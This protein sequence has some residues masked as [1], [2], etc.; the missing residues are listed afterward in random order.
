MSTPQ[1]D[2]V[3]VLMLE[4]R[5]FDSL[6]G[7]AYQTGAPSL[8]LPQGSS[9]TFDG[10]QSVNLNEFVNTATNPSISSPPIQ[11]AQGFTVPTVDPGEEL[12]HVNL[13]FFNT[14][15]FPPPDPANMLGYM[16]DFVNVMTALGIDVGDIPGLAPQVM[17]SYTPQQLP[18]LNQL[19][20]AYAVSDAWYASVPS[21]TNPNR[22]FLMCGTSLGLVNNGQ[23]E[24]PNSPAK[25]IESMLGMSIGD[26]RFDAPTIFNALDK[27]GRGWSVFWQAPYLPQK[28]STLLQ[29]GQTLATVLAVLAPTVGVA[30]LAAWKAL[31]PYVGYM[32]SLTNGQLGSCYTWRLFPQIQNIS[33]A[34]S[35]FQS[36]DQFHKL[37]QAGNLPA[38]SYIEPY[39]SISQ[40][41]MASQ[42]SLPK[43]LITALGND[44]HP[45]SNLLVGEQFVKDVY[46][47]LISHQDAWQ[48]TLFLITFDEFVG[49]FDHETTGLQQG[50]AQPPWGAGTPPPLATQN[51]FN[52]DRFGGRVPTIVISP[53][54]QAGTVFRSPT[55]TPY[56]HTS[57]IA[58]ALKLLGGSENLP[59]FGSRA[60]AAPTFDNV[61]TLSQPR[62]DAANLG[63]MDKNHNTGDPVN[64]GDNFLL[65]NKNGHHL[66]AFQ[67]AGKVTMPSVSSG[68]MSMCV[69]VGVAALFP[70]LGE[71]THAPLSFVTP[72]PNVS[73]QVPDQAQTYLISREAG[74]WAANALGAWNDS[75]DC[76]YYT[77]YFDGQYLPYQT[78]TIQ[79]KSR[80]GQ[81]LCYGDQVVL[82]N[83]QFQPQGLTRDTRWGQSSWITTSTSPDTWTIEPAPV[84]LPS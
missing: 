29:Y 3:V 58:T 23:L 33:N 26:D 61:M 53:Y 10:L 5:S 17:Q 35:K 44:Y 41:T 30:V 81:P 16:Q 6:L 76:Y 39:W 67:S 31:Q 48:K 45:P 56:D 60:E 11:G 78:W 65:L 72:A 37:A 73:G 68:V 77:P 57:M 71:G 1:I 79:N 19:A 46:T 22:A 62:T 18:V 51:N 20:Q 34:S 21:Q 4:N 54:V 59:D 40:T 69:D 12:E 28:I 25:T 52:F 63:F 49:T 74:L 9:S 43:A 24:D 27:A 13:Q 38:F 8:V 14:E 15:T 66:T 75:H 2:H 83:N 64:Y 70:T 42:S 80:P 50:L 84:T 32:Q 47:S 55:E 82:I 7:W 36:L